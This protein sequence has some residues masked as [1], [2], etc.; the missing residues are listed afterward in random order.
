[1]ATDNYPQMDMSAWHQTGEGGNGKTY[2]N[3]SKP[4]IMLKV[5]DGIEA[6][7]EE[8]GVDDIRELKGCVQ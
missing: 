3:P 1:M 8:Y 7:M 2:E 4:G 6:Y 5:I